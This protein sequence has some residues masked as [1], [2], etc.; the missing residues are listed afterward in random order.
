MR[1]HGGAARVRAA[2]QRAHSTGRQ[3]GDVMGEERHAAGTRIAGRAGASAR[4][5][6]PTALVLGS[7]RR[8][9][10]LRFDRARRDAGAG[11]HRGRRLHQAPLDD[12]D[13]AAGRAVRSAPHRAAGL[14]G[15]RGLAERR[16]AARRLLRHRLRAAAQLRVAS[17]ADEPPGRQ[18]LQLLVPHAL[19]HGRASRA[20]E[21]GRGAPHP[22]LLRRL[23]GVRAPRRR[24]GALPRLVEPRESHGRHGPREGLHAGRLRPRGPGGR[25][26][27]PRAVRG[28]TP[29]SPAPA[30]T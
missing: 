7:Q 21:P 8:Q 13:V 24:P 29:T 27:R 20:G 22:L 18:G 6:E 1:C 25:G 23:R 10:R 5:Q 16:G 28:A 4:L 9:P 12:A 3:P 30:T 11:P 14:L 26:Q 15:R 19:R 2:P 17:A